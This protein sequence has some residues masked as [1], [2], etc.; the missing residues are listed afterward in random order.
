MHALVKDDPIVMEKFKASVKEIVD[1]KTSKP[2]LIIFQEYSETGLSSYKPQK[3]YDY[4]MTNYEL[5]EKVDCIEVL[6]PKN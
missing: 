4:V 1:L 5:K 3:V 6:I 2:K